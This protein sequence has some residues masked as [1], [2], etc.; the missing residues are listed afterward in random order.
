MYN[1]I[2]KIR[3][4]SPSDPFSVSLYL[5]NKMGDIN[6]SYQLPLLLAFLLPRWLEEREMGWTGEWSPGFLEPSQ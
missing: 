6:A 2:V 4:K 3:L 1:F 5:N